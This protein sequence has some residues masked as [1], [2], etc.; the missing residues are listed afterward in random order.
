MIKNFK[1]VNI[2][3]KD[4]KALADFYRAIGAPV[5][6]EDD[7]YDGWYI[8]NPEQ[9]GTVCVWNENNWGKSTAGFVTVVLE[10][11]DV[12]KT[13]AEIKSKGIVI[14]PPRTADWGGQELVF[15]DPDGN[16]VMLL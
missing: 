2:S 14:D 12:Q 16:V 10:T 5:F 6:I 13:Y 9:G 4:P 11:D 3:S 7:N 15:N 8:G 1:C